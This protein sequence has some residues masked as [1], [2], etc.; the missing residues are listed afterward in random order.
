[1]AIIDKKSLKILIIEPLGSARK[2]V[3]DT[4]KEAGFNEFVSMDTLK[5]AVGFLEAEE[6][7]WLICPLTTGEGANAFHML[8]IMNRYPPLKNACVSLLIADEE[9]VHMPKAFE[10]GLM[11]WHKKLYTK[12]HLL[13]EFKAVA[14]T[15]NKY[16][17]NSFLV[18]N[19]YA[20]KAFRARGHIKSLLNLQQGLVAQKPDSGTALLGLAEAQFQNNL[21]EDGKFTLSRAQTLNI[22]GWDKVAS[23]FLPPGETLNLKL[24]IGNCMVVDPDET[25][26][27]TIQECLA[28]VGNV[29]VVPFSDG[30]TALQWLS[31]NPPPDLLIQEW[32]IPQVTGPNFI[33][34]V[35]QLGLQRLPIVVL[36]SLT[37]KQDLTLLNEMSVASTIEKPV[38]K[39]EFV[40]Q[41]GT[42]LQEEKNPFQPR[43]L[44]RKI[45]EFL[46]GGNKEKAEE[47]RVRLEANSNSP[48]AL[49]KYVRA[50]FLFHDQKFDAAQKL[51][52]ESLQL[53]P[54][55]LR[56][57][58]LLGKI[59]IKKRDFTGA[60]KCLK[61][62]QEM[63][64]KNVERLC[65]LAE[66]QSE[67]GDFAAAKESIVAA[68]G[69]D[70]GNQAIPLE[71]SK[72]A[73]RSG[74]IALA[75]ELFLNIA[76]PLNAVIA[77]MNNSA[78]AHIHSGDF[79]AGVELYERTLKAL[80]ETD[81]E[82]SMKVLYNLAMAYARQ[83]KLQEAGEVLT[84]AA[85]EE[86]FP[87]FK[88]IKQL[89]Q[90][91]CVAVEQQTSLGL[92]ISAAPAEIKDPW[93][94]EPPSSNG[95]AP[96]PES[97]A[98]PIVAGERCCYLV[99]L[100]DRDE[101]LPSVPLL[102][103]PPKF[104]ARAAYAREESLGLDRM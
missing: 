4:V 46:L 35:R 100:C 70:A 86:G 80:P 95:G 43:A 72:V 15:L 96:S 52:I 1:M 81:A 2:L 25:V 91:I 24:T 66:A 57:I 39:A 54:D 56:A 20:Q 28:A 92:G 38:N 94:V 32:R 41:V 55:Q 3:A 82:L 47:Y 5:S 88:K 79:D 30:K 12:D 51:S 7:D 59:L 58:H 42:M 74:D 34:R 76:T 29:K 19:E 10:L 62:A 65:E 61:R 98:L 101:G 18:A 50:L 103:D 64:P 90:K 78:V 26:Q 75:K 16:K 77:D 8:Q 102:T 97:A 6:L 63:S 33:Q 60:S 40:K 93:Y 53:Q 69:I 89:K 73:L 9:M 44:E 17:G 31:E 48:E 22:Q 71:E 84:R 85:A 45:V 36:S 14:E 23:Q 87:I 83:D 67:L 99:F 27:K 37:T 49:K 11:S 13:S 21:Q 68:K 104:K